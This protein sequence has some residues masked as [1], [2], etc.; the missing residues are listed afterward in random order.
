MNEN[1][2]RLEETLAG[3]ERLLIVP[4]NDPDP[5][6]MASALALQYLAAQRWGITATIAYRG[7]VGRA[8][9][10]ALVRYL[11]CPLRRLTRAALHGNDPI[12]LV[13]TQ[14]GAG[15]HPLLPDRPPLIVVDHHIRQQAAD[16]AHLCDVRP[17]LGATSTI[18]AEY[19]RAA[20]LE[21]PPSLATALFYGIKT[22]TMGL[23]RGASAADAEAYF[24]LQPLIDVEALVE[25][26]HA[27]VPLDYFQRLA[28]A[29]ESARIYDSAV[30]AYVGLMHRPDL[31]AE[32]ADLLLRLEG[33]V[34]VVCLGAY[35]YQ[36]VA[37]VR[38]R[39]S[40]G[41]AEGLAQAVVAGEGSAGGHGMVAGG[42]IPLAGRDPQAFAETLT[43]R[44]LGYLHGAK[45]PSGRPLLG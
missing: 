8:E 3:V 13:D 31:A 16:C 6:A 17:G 15:N 43:L 11:G 10:K 18:M 37:T 9:N 44:A 45:A 21:P 14:P 5:D 1:L 41:G 42:Q 38:T 34:W 19:L 12:A 20:G 35:R 32:I 4:H 2:A 40:K 33:T 23:Y 28:A 39:H 24:S 27:Q 29:L 25:I 26:E 22:D 36:M 30:I 7:I